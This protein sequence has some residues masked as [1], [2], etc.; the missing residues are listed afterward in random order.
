MSGGQ[1][2]GHD[3]LATALAVSE[4]LTRGILAAVPVGVVHV[5]IDGSVGTANAEALRVLGLSY[6]E[7]TRRYT[8]D[9]ET[10]TILQ[11]GTPCPVDRYPVS[12]ALITGEVQPAMT[13]GVRRPSGDVCWCIFRAVP[14]KDPAS[15]ATTGAVVTFHDVTEQIKVAETL[16]R[17]EAELKAIV[18]SAPN[19]I[20]TADREGRITF[21]NRTAPNLDHPVD[22]STVVGQSMLDWINARDIPMFK[23]NLRR[24]VEQ[25]ETVEYEMAGLDGID[26]NLYLTHLGPI[27]RDDRV[28]AIAGVV[29][30]MTERRRAEE[31]RARLVAQLHEARRLEALGRL[32]GGVAHDFNNLLTIIRGSVDL[33]LA[34]GVDDASRHRLQEIAD[35]AERGASLTRQLLAFG[36]QQSLKPRVIDLAA[37]VHGVLPMLER[38][39][40]DHVVLVTRHEP[41]LARVLADP[42]EIERVLVN[43]VTNAQDA[44]PEAGGE[45]SITTRPVLATAAEDAIYAAIEVRDNGTGMDPS[46]LAHAFEPFFTTKEVGRGTGLGLPTVFGIVKQSGGKI[47][48]DSPSEGGTCVRVLLPTLSLERAAAL[49]AAAGLVTPGFPT[50]AHDRGS[51]SETVLVVEDEPRLREVV[52]QVV[53]DGGYR[54]ITVESAE[55][56]M[57]LPDADL[58]S[59]QV[60]LTDVRMPKHSGTA[61]AARLRERK[62][63]LKVL[64]MSGHLPDSSTDLPDDYEF[65]SKPFDQAALCAKLRRLLGP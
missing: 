59:V 23:E 31:E 29:T 6:D 53:R 63:S 61:V 45:I 16:Q 42:S 58:G 3:D 28:V 49:A 12:R 40:G 46:T 43:L 44:I 25:G 14:V 50:L 7:L 64:L 35:A 5:T 47:E 52:C 51:E 38:L 19:V 48:V 34:R 2:L 10:E 54:A 24:V 18:S 32:S 8:T 33:L 4:Q 1:S 17:S 56:A 60:L 13:I 57:A 22:T 15:G 27:F 36:R 39:L 41:G 55:A 65:I 21:M 11:D 26:P 9:F 20:L 30:V 62:P 37:I